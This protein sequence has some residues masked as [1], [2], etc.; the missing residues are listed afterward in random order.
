MEKGMF[1]LVEIAGKGI[2]WKILK[3]R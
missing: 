3:G 2:L 1:R